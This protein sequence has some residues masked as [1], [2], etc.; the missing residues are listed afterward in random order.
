MAHLA[1]AIYI[2]LHVGI[3]AQ[4]S[5]RISSHEGHPRSMQQLQSK[6]SSQSANAIFGQLNPSHVQLSNE[7]SI[8]G[9]ENGLTHVSGQHEKVHSCLGQLGQN[10]AHSG[11]GQSG[12]TTSFVRQ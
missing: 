12:Q 4:Y 5:D 11:Q 9:Q 7:Q 3:T 6:H 1:Q 2:S 10:G 8:L